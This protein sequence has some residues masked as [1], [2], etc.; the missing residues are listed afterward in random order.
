MEPIKLAHIAP[1]EHILKADKQSDIVMCLYHMLDNPKYKGLMMLE[2]KYKILDNSYYEKHKDDAFMEQFNN[3]CT[4]IQSLIDAALEIKANCVVLPDGIITP[5]S[6]DI[7]QQH[8]LD[9]MV[10][11][12][13]KEQLK[14]AIVSKADLIGLSFIHA[15]NI[16][17][18]NVAFREN[19]RPLLL[20]TIKLAAAEL[21]GLT[22]L[23]VDDVLRKRIHLLGLWSY[24]ELIKCVPYTDIVNS[25]DTSTAVWLGLNGKDATKMKNKFYKKV[26]FTCNKEWNLLCSWNMG[27]MR[28]VTKA[29]AY[30][31]KDMS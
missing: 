10:V 24:D 2:T 15:A 25:C 16:I 22:G 11:P 4:F 23:C 3:T 27:C 7:V 20:K 14:E 1:I 31:V 12:T 21:T 6:I 8:D 18:L 13:N 9:V 19:I 29:G 5:E 28:G 26:D 17:S 30:L